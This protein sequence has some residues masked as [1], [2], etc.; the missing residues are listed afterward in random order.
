LAQS[1]LEELPI[2]NMIPPFFE[3]LTDRTLNEE[4]KARR[5][6]NALRAGSN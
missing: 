5:G 4:Y 3:I 6:N 1:I 2:F